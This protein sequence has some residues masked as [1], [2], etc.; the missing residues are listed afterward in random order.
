MRA[1]RRG[2]RCASRPAAATTG[3]QPVLD[4]A[5]SQARTAAELRGAAYLRAVTFYSYPEGR[6]EFAARVSELRCRELGWAPSLP[7]PPQLPC[8]PQPAALTHP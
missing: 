2:A 8:A 5:M 3:G 1:P 7:T 6:S 4:L